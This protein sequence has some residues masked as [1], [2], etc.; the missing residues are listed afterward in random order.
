MQQKGSQWGHMFAPKEL[1]H[2][3][4]PLD[5]NQRGPLI[6]HVIEKKWVPISKRVVC[7]LLASSTTNPDNIPLYWNK[8]GRVVAIVAMQQFV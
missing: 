3:I 7:K 6:K 5:R 8:K 2:M 1:H 4:H